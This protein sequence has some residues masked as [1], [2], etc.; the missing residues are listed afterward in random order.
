MDADI[1]FEFCDRLAIYLQAIIQLLRFDTK[2]R[3]MAQNHNM[4]QQH[5]GNIPS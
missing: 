3:C 4:T 1:M 2:F 5:S